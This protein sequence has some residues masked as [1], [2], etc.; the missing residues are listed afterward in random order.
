LAFGGRNGDETIDAVVSIAVLQLIPDPVAALA[1]MARVLRPGGRLA[2]IVPTA[3]R[4][5]RLWRALPNVG[6]YAFGEDEIADILEDHSF[7]TVR[8]KNVG[9]FQWV[10]AK[11][12]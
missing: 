2:V 9:T 10:R 11:R 6:A 4:A 12:G 3:E 8:T 1:E 7:A 5:A